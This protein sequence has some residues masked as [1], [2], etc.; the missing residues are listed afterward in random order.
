MRLG[1]ILVDL[2]SNAHRDVLSALAE[3][4]QVPVLSIDGP[5]AISPELETLSPAFLRRFRCFPVNQDDDAIR[6]AM[7]DPNDFETRSTVSSCTGL[8][9]LVGIAPEKEII[10]A[11]DRYYG[12]GGKNETE[13]A[14]PVTDSEDL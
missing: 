1:K 4:L 7:A 3:Q 12:Q 11:I 10:D 14:T 13:L 9:V 6:L 2:G 5:P 8:T